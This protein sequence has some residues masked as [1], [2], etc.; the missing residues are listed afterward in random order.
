MMLAYLVFVIVVA[1]AAVV[2]VLMRFTRRVEK[3]A[4]AAVPPDGQFIDIDGDRLHYVDM[5]S[6]PPIVFV[7]GLSGQLRNFAYLPLAELARTHRVVLVDRPG[8]G[9]STRGEGH[10]A[11]IPAQARTLVRFMQA[12]GL[13]KP[14]LVGHSLGGAIALAVGLDHPEAVRALGL[15]APL[16]HPV[17]QPPKAFKAMAIRSAA[18][19]RFIGRTLAVPIGMMSGKVTLEMVFGPDRAPADFLIRGGGVLGF[20][21]GNFVNAANDMIAI[22]AVMPDMVARYPGLT[23]PVYVLYG[24]GDRVL[25][26]QAHGEALTRANPAT[27]LTVVEGGHMLPVTLPEVTMGWLHEVIAQTQPASAPASMPAHAANDAA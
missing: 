2:L 3:R 21:S 18:V 14:V 9:Y 23:V 16:T 19:R 20:R 11:S 10:S 12:L 1:L 5:G 22:Q 17:T 4:E 7:H 15:I 24:R 26:W 13:E 27:L 8:S 25:N 6:G